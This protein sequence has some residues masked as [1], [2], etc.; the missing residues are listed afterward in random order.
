MKIQPN[1][2]V[3]MLYGALLLTGC[4]AYF[5]A[6][7]LFFVVIL[8]IG[9]AVGCTLW[10]SIDESYIGGHQGARRKSINLR[11]LIVLAIVSA[12]AAVATYFISMRVEWPGLW[13]GFTVYCLQ[14]LALRQPGR[15][16]WLP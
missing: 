11:I 5:L 8:A 7:A 14:C 12:I 4:A 2:F 1:R 10:Q 15:Q 9:T 16:T 13:L 3:T 6:P